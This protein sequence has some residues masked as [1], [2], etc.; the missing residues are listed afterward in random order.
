MQVIYKE[1]FSPHR[2]HIVEAI[3]RGDILIYPTDTIYGLGC[4][5]LLPEAVQK[6]REMKKRDPKNP[7]SVIAPSKEW[8]L[9]YCEVGDERN[10]D[11]LPGPFTLILNRKTDCPIASEVNPYDSTLGVR[12]P[13]HWFTEIVTE[14][15]V[16]FVTTSVNFSGGSFMKK[17][18]DIPEEIVSA[19][20]YCIYEGEKRGVPSTKVNIAGVKTARE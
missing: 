7:L 19:T 18:A 16:P 3:I 1:E 15:G 11:K 4:N 9:R 8:I 6:I 14:A 20:D 13:S 10:L 17:I 2:T 12:I 5:A